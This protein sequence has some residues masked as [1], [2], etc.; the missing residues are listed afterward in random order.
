MAADPID[1]TPMTVRVEDVQEAQRMVAALRQ[2]TNSRYGESAAILTTGG[3]EAEVA[4]LLVAALQQLVSLLA[5]G[6]DVALVPVHRDVSLA[7]A[8]AL[9][10]VPLP[11]LVELLD[12][13]DLPSIGMGD[14]RRVRL[15]DLVAIQERRADNRRD[16]A[17][18][19]AIAQEAGAYD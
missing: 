1:D 15:R 9:L 19:L 4:P 11:S 12:S 6:D 2:L 3:R 13:A 7:E 17:T 8:A 14:D 5:R 10:D 16:L 18:A